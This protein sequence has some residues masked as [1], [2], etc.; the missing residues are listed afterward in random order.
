[1]TR[2]ISPAR[3]LD[4][5]LARYLT[6]SSVLEIADGMPS[7][8][9]DASY[10]VVFAGYKLQDISNYRAAIQAWF[11][12]VSVGGYLVIVVPHAFLYERQ[13]ALPSRWSPRQRRLYTPRSLIEEIEEALVP[14]S[15]RVRCL[16]DCDA[17]YDYALEPGMF[18]QGQ[19]DVVLALQKIAPPVWGLSERSA[20]IKPAPT[21]TFEP[22]RTRIEAA[23]RI[24]VPRIL[25]LKLDHLGDFIMGTAALEKARATFPDAEITLVVGSWN[26]AMAEELRLFDHVLVFDAFPRNTSEEK[27]DVRGKVSEFEAKFTAEYDLAIDLRTDHDTRILLDSVRARIRAGIGAKSQFEFLDIFLPIDGTRRSEAAWERQIPARDFSAAQYCQ[28][29]RHRIYCNVPPVDASGGAT[30]WGPY[31]HLPSGQ[32]LFEPFIDFDW[33][34]SGLIRYDIAIDAECVVEGALSGGDLKEVRFQNRVDGARFEFRL[35]CFETAQPPRFQF[36]GGRLIKQS[37]ESVLHQ[38]EYLC[39]LIELVALRVNTYGLLQA[40]QEMP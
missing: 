6:S 24:A 5:P 1:M 23:S 14:N 30:I 16:S 18:P 25:I 8:A 38:S 20:D 27:D 39:M 10:E 35:W 12:R 33:K 36:Y 22:P 34:G 40:W 29:T 9:P 4:G 19:H 26:L 11:A 37:S 31:H 17:A 32:Y 13:S 28:R 15:Y 3:Y 7:A 2:S 21:D